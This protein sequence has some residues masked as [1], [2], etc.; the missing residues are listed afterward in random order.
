[1][2]DYDV[3]LVLRNVGVGNSAYRVGRCEHRVQKGTRVDYAESC[4]V[5]SA[6][7]LIRWVS[8]QGAPKTFNHQKVYQF[9]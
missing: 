7:Q 3:S 6:R 5:Q 1:M 2:K 8:N 4:G 9:V